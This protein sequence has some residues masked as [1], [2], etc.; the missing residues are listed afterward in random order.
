MVSKEKS[1]SQLK[2]EI[3]DIENKI[4]KEIKDIENKIKKEKERR[5]LE[6]KLKSLKANSKPKK[7]GIR[8]RIRKGIGKRTSGA[9]DRASKLTFG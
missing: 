8:E 9:L 6:E 5:V 4:K 7:Q 2:K 3:K 1:I